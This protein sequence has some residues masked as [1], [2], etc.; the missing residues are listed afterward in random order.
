M[1]KKDSHIIRGRMRSCLSVRAAI[2]WVNFC[3]D[4]DSESLDRWNRSFYVRSSEKVVRNLLNIEEWN[5]K[6]SDN[7]HL[8]FGSIIKC[9]VPFFL[10]RI[11]SLA[12]SEAEYALLMLTHNLLPTLRKLIKCSRNCNYLE[13]DGKVGHNETQTIRGTQLQSKKKMGISHRAT[14]G[15]APEKHSN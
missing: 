14:F 8:V 7:W 15:W 9:L 11:Y 10:A 5:N 2:R 1:N 6:T 12:T 4:P 3:C 13:C